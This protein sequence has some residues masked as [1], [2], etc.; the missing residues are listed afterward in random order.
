MKPAIGILGIAGGVMIVMIILQFSTRRVSSPKPHA[1]EIQTAHSR[2]TSMP[3][4][5]AGDSGNRRSAFRRPV[6]PNN[7]PGQTSAHPLGDE[8][9]A[10]IGDGTE[11][12]VDEL[13]RLK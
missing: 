11:I 10:A 13:P 1:G 9:R 12:P 2:S 6:R 7:A 3:N 5:S 8:L 4:L